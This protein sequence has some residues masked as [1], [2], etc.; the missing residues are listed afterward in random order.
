VNRLTKRGR[1]C[2]LG[3][4][5]FNTCTPCCACARDCALFWHWH[6]CAIPVP[7]PGSHT[8]FHAWTA[9]APFCTAVTLAQPLEFPTAM[10]ACIAVLAFVRIP[11]S[12]PGATPPQCQHSHACSAPSSLHFIHPP[13]PLCACVHAHF[14]VDYNFFYMF[15]FA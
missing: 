10:A 2:T 4:L 5:S 11:S 7:F 13:C 1:K 6:V 14:P 15:V 8:P 12:P 3:D 9:G